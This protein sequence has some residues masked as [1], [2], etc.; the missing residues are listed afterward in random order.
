VTSGALGL[1][2]VAL[3]APAPAVDQG[4]TVD[5]CVEMALEGNAQLGAA[6]ARV[7]EYEARLAEVESLHYPKLWALGFLAPM[8]TVEGDA[9]SPVHRDLRPSA[10][11]PYAHLEATLAQPLY[12]FGRIEAG[13]RAAEA[14]AAVEQARLREARNEVALEV[15]RLIAW[16]GYASG[17]EPELD[18]AAAILKH[19]IGQA[20]DLYRR[21]TG[22]VSNV[23]QLRLEAAAVEL[24]RAR[25]QAKHGGDLAL[26]AL[27]QTMGLGPGVEVHLAQERPPALPDTDEPLATLLSEAGRLRPEWEELDRGRE[28]AEAL[29]RAERRADLPTLFLGANLRI[30]YTPTRDDATNPYQYDPYNQVVG[31]VALGL[32]ANLDP[33]RT[34]ARGDAAQADVDEVAA[35]KRFAD[36]GI[37]LQVTRAH[38]E[39]ILARQM[40]ELARQQARITARWVA[41]AQIAWQTGTGDP[42]DLLEGVAADVAARVTIQA[43]LRDYQVARAELDDAVG[44]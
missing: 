28:A 3:A 29:E 9:T 32:Q 12:T 14:R 22:E 10:W 37:P 21:G 7:R 13:E 16:H 11:G 44:R 41:S 42:R 33:W 36:S 40:V 17:V 30:D 1:L 43:A 15:R 18:E 6:E 24:Q 5:Q 38:A 27:A 25:L 8:Y 26:A 4:W 39:L 35:L 34:R 31:G 20:S 23:D 19:A 2:L